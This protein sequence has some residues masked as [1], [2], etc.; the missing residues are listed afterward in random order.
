MVLPKPGNLRPMA[1]DFNSLGR[2]ISGAVADG[3]VPGL[4]LGVAHAGEVRLLA[5]Y[6]QRQL[7]PEPAAATLD[8]IYDLASLTKALVTSALVM[9]A[10]AEGRM[11]LD[12]PLGDFLPRLRDRPDATVGRALAH[13][14]GFPAHR[15]FYEACFAEGGVGTGYRDTIV[16]MAAREPPG[17]EPGTRSIYSDLGFILLGAAVEACLGDRLDRL[18]ARR[19]FAPLGL[20]RLGFVGLPGESF[21]ATAGLPVAPT[22][23]C[24]VR[25]RIVQG[26]V[27]DLNAYAMGGIAGHAGLFGSIADVLHLV[28][29]LMAAYHGRGFADASPPIPR[30]VLREFWRPAGVPGSTWR[31]GWDGPS[32]H[33]SL[34]G[35]LLSRGAVGHLSFT[36]CSIWLD[37][38][39]ETA[40]VLLCNRVHPTVREDGGFRVLRPRLHDAALHAI[41]YRAG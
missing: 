7:A 29:A 35:E 16:E 31:F 2:L 20:S 41:G 40:V 22:E 14:A 19:L 38:E 30:Q 18:A 12:R 24:P 39:Q 32:A 6:G 5:A 9:Q 37:P 15:R 28:L 36:G 13:T 34:A 27:H 33:G 11:Q 10:V 3:A 26:E 25:V 4:C 1:A 8:T 17:Y 21:I 23:R